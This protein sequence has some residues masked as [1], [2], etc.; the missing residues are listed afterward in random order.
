M[1]KHR[2]GRA[3]SQRK[4][5]HFAVAVALVLLILIAGFGGLRGLAYGSTSAQVWSDR[6]TGLAIA[7]YD[8]IAYFTDGRARLGSADYEFAW[9][10]VTWRFANSGNMAVFKAHPTIYAPQFGGYDALGVARGVTG[11]GNPLIWIIENTKLYLFFSPDDKKAWQKRSKSWITKG[12]RNWPAL[13]RT[14][15]N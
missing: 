8:P 11:P 4:S 10:G 14:L 12:G 13:S 15:S 7:G 5:T 1:T 3:D 2:S 9:R 6:E